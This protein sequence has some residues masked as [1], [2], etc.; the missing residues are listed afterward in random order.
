MY[1]NH[2]LIKKYVF[3]FF[4]HVNQKDITKSSLF[5]V[6]LSDKSSMLTFSSSTTHMMLSL[7]MP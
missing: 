4:S 6:I 3:F 2:K 5:S 7:F 1:K